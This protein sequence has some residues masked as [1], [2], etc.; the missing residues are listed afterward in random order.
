MVSGLLG[1]ALGSTLGTMLVKSFPRAHPIICGVGLLVSAPALALAIT[2]VRDYFYPTFILIFIAETALNLNW[3]IVADMSMYVVIPPRRS[4]AEAFQILISHMFGDAGSP[5]LVGVISENLKRTLSPRQAPTPQID[6][7]SLQY[8]LFVTC[9]IEVIGGVFFLIAAFY[10][11][12]DKLQADRA[13][14]V[15]SKVV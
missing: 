5:Y 11:V 12:K 1:V 15:A 2:L 7:S 14:A 6:F 10:I 13:I 8:A 3:A 4:T 9:F